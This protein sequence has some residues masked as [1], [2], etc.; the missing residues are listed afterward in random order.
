[1]LTPHSRE[2]WSML[3][4]PSILAMITHSMV[5]SEILRRSWRSM[6]LNSGMALIE[7]IFLR[8][9]FHSSMRRAASISSEVIGRMTLVPAVS[10]APSSKTNSPSSQE[11]TVKMASSPLNSSTSAWTIS[12][13]LR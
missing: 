7:P 1:M 12:P 3:F 9:S 13:F 10:N 5:E 8:S 2:I 6:S 4:L 11:M